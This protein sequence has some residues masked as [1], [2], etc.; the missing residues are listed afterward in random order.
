M[1]T[2]NFRFRIRIYYTL[3][4]LFIFSLSVNSQDKY[5]KID[6]FINKFVTHEYFNGAVL[7][8]QNSDVI[9]KKAYGL[10]NREWE[11]NNTIDTKFRIG[12]LTK[13]FTALIILQLAEQG[14][15]KL[16]GTISD[17]LDY[18][19]KDYGDKVT[20]HHL[21]THTSGMPIFSS[22]PLPEAFI[23]EY[24]VKDFVVKY[25]SDSL[26]FEPGSKFQYSN[27]GYY[28]LGA[29]IEAVT[30]KKYE[31]NLTQMILKPCGM[32]NTGYDHP[33]I[34]LPKRASGYGIDNGELF[35][36]RY[37]NMSIP[38]S[39]GA[40]YSTVEDFLLW[41][42]A[43][44]SGKLLSNELT[45]LMLSPHKENY[46]YGWYIAKDTLTDIDN[47]VTVCSHGGSIS[48]FNNLI[49]RRLEEKIL[50]VIFSNVYGTR[51]GAMSKGINQILHNKQV[52]VIFKN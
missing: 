35:N 51:L 42:E 36:A 50:I 1:V 33:E 39:A 21:L 9:F 8:A 48:Q 14:K 52:D 20:I 49:V 28:I 27:S 5:E 13:Q 47:P 6:D 34:I 7:V 11:I 15:L 45:K 41:D 29:I 26:D 40:I 19:D 10:A 24:P 46:G 44:Y 18:Y 23:G 4:F 22:K 3:L 32:K 16:D 12:S 37:Q 30:G 43:L 17:Y 25:C 38:F 2:I 31:E